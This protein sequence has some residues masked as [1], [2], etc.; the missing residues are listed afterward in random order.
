[1]KATISS[2]WNRLLKKK[3][4]KS[5]NVILNELTKITQF[6]NI[7]KFSDKVGALTTELNEIQISSLGKNNSEAISKTSCIIT[8]HSFKNGL[9][10]QEIIR[11]INASRVKTQRS[12]W[13]SRR[14]INRQNQIVFQKLSNRNNYRNY[15]N[16]NH[17]I[18]RYNNNNNWCIQNKSRQN[19]CEM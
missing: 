5:P 11:T 8:F 1:M 3:T 17:S 9:K 12:H 19:R 13:H 16:N 7:R 6:D 14:N 18:N 2:D 10:D 15:R 4:N